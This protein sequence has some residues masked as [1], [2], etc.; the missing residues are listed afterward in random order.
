M[1]NSTPKLT[2]RRDSAEKTL[3]RQDYE[4]ARKH[5][6]I[7]YDAI[8]AHCGVSKNKAA[9]WGKPDRLL[10]NAEHL[11]KMPAEIRAFLR[12]REAAREG[13][14]VVLAE[15][16]GLDNHQRQTEMTVKMCDLMSLHAN[17]LADGKRTRNE[18]VQLIPVLDEVIHALT[19]A[20]TTLQQELDASEGNVFPFVRTP[21]PPPPPGA[22]TA[23]PAAAPAAR[24]SLNRESA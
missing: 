3:W 2:V 13:L 17:V 22:G 4:A 11:R 10:P 23:V 20:R 1:R 15:A 24:R 7:S 18:T 5:F 16:D 19:S 14:A 12:A 8:G 6:G 21:A 9:L